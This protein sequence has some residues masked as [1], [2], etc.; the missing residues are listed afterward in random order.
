LIPTTAPARPITASTLFAAK[1]AA[2]L[3]G[4]EDGAEVVADAVGDVCVVGVDEVVVTT[5]DVTGSG[6]G[7]VEL[8]DSVEDVT[9]GAGGGVDV[10]V[11]GGGAAVEVVVETL[12]LP[13]CGRPCGHELEPEEKE[14]S[15]GK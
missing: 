7:R 4:G 12:P 13:P 1:G 6:A 11:T 3:D 10:D 9:G 2:A 14:P 15:R 8:T 5:A